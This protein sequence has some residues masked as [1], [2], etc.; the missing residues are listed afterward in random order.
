MFVADAE[1]I[2]ALQG[3][4]SERIHQ[5]MDMILRGPESVQPLVQNTERFTI[6]Y[7]SFIDFL[8][9]VFILSS[10]MLSLEILDSRSLHRSE[11]NM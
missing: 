10:K 2:L 11:G 3:N 6:G 8:L 7:V 9:Y 1:V 5:I 4:F